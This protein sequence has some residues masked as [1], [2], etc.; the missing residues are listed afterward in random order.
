MKAFTLIALF[1]TAALGTFAQAPTIN[2]FPVN[3]TSSPGFSGATGSTMTI[4]GTN[5]TGATAVTFGG[6]PASSFTVVSPTQIT[7]VVA[8]GSKGGVT[9]TTPQGTATSA[10]TFTYL[11]LSRIVTSFGGYWSSTTA[12]NNATQ[13]DSSHNLLGFTYNGS[14]YSTGAS[15]STLT[16]RGISFTPGNYRAFPVSGIAGTYSS[17]AVYLAIANKVDGNPTLGNLAGVS[18]ATIRSVLIDGVRGLDLGTGVTNLPTTAIMT[19]NLSSISIPTIADAEPDIL[20]TQIAD[21]SVGNDRFEFVDAAG[22]TVG[23][24]LTQDMTALPTFGVYR[25]DLFGFTPGT[26]YNVANPT[27]VNA[28]NGTKGIRIVGLKLSDFG[29]T[30]ANASSVKAM[31]ITPSGNSDYAFIAY[32]ARIITSAPNIS[33]NDGTTISSVCNNGNAVLSVIGTASGGGA[34]TY[35]WERSTNG[36]TIWSA[37]SN[38]GNFSGAT[39]NSL[40]VANP[41]SNDKYR[42]TVSE[43]GGT[44]NTSADF[45][46]T[47]SPTT[48]GGT[49]AGSTS[50]CTGTNSTTFTLSGHT[51]SV[52]RWESSTNGFS[53]ITT[54]AN[55]TASLTVT[56]VSATTQYR[57]VVQSGACSIANSTVASVTYNASVGGSVA[58]SAP[59]VCTGTNSTT[60]TLSGHTGNI[61]RWESST[62]NFSSINTIANTT[63]TLT[64]T[65]LTAT[66]QYRAII[67]NASCASANSSAATVTVNPTTVGG[68]IAGSA[69]VCTGSNSTTL[70]LSSNTGTIVKWQSST[71]NFS[72]VITDVANTTTTLTASNLTATT[73]YRA[74]VQ[75]GICASVNSSTATVTV[76]P[77]S[78]GGTVAGSASVCTGSNS[79][80]LTLSSNTGTIVKWQSSTDNFSSVITDI[81]NTT[82][83]LT[84]SNLTA[85]TQYR[86]VVQSG[87]CASANS[88][89]ATVTVSPATVG[90]TITGS[91]S[92]CTGSNSA[93]L[94]LSGSTGTIVKWQSSTDNFSSVITDIANTTATLT[95]T[96]LNATTQYRAVV[97][98]GVCASANSSTA[99]V[100]VSPATVGGTI[101]GSAAVCTGSNFTTLTLSVNTGS[102]VKW[103]SSTDNF[104]SVITDIANTT[105]TLIASNLNA[106]TKYRAVVQSGVCASANSSIATITVSPAS[107]GGTIAGSA[108]VCTG[109]NSTTL[110]LSGSTGTIVKWQSSTD[111]FSSLITD[112]ANTTNTLTATNLT[113]TTRYRAVLQSG[114]C[115]SAISS[116]ATIT[117]NAVGQWIGG[118]NGDWNLPSNWCGGVPSTPSH[119]SIPSGSIVTITSG[120]ALA[121]TVN[122]AAGGNLVMNGSGNL[123]ISAGGTFINNGTF[124]A[125]ASTTGKVSFAGN[126]T[127]SG[128]TTF[129]NIDTYG[130]LD[131]GTASTVS[132]EF[133]LQTGASVTGHSPTYLCPTS[134]LVYNIGGT[135]PRSLEWPS[136]SS[137]Q[138]LPSNVIVKNNT[139][140]NFPVEGAGYVCN[141]LTV[142]PGSAL[143]QNFSGS[144][145]PLT[146]GRH[147]TIDGLLTLGDDQGDD[148][149]LGG[150]WTRNQGVFNAN[151]RTVTFTSAANSVITGPASAT[152]DGNG[153][154][155]GETFYNINLNK[156]A[157]SNTVELG[158]NITVVNEL[159]VSKGTFDLVNN[160]VTIVSNA[161]TT[162]H[163]APVSA[164]GATVNY[165]GTGRFIIQRHLS[166]GSGSTSRR[167]RMLTAPVQAAGAPTISQAWQEGVS[168]A[169]RNAPVDPWPGFG[170]TI[171]KSTT[172]N[173]ADGYDQGSTNN[174]SIYG[175][176][177]TNGIMQW[178]TLPSTKVAVT[179]HEGYMLFA[180]GNRS[181]IVSTPNINANTT[182]LEPRGK[183]N[184]GNIQKSVVAGFQIIGNPYASAID[185]NKLTFSNYKVGSTTYNGSAGTI[186]GIGLT[187][188]MW[189]PK[190][191][192]SSS[193]GKWITCSSNGDGTYTITPSTS[194]LPTDGV[195]Q[196]GVA[197]MIKSDDA[198]GSLFFHETDKVSTSS[199][200][201]IASRGTGSNQ[202]ISSLTSTLMVGTGASA[203]I[204][205]GVVNSY[206]P[207]YHDEVDNQDAPGISTFNSNDA[208]RIKSE[209]QYLAIERR[210]EVADNDTI[211][212][213]LQNV[214]K[215]AYTLQFKPANMSSLLTAVLEDNFTGAATPLNMN[216]TNSIAFSVT[217]DVKSGAEDRFR[218]VFKQV[219]VLPIKFSSLKAYQQNDNIAVQWTVENEQNMVKYEVEKSANG[220]DF[221][222]VN[223]TKATG[224]DH[225]TTTYNW[226]DLNS[227]KGDNFYR[228]KSVSLNGSIE[229]SKIVKVSLG[230][231]KTG[232]SVYPNPVK[233]G[234]IGLQLSNAPA[235]TYTI[236]LLNNAGQV[237]EKSTLK[238]AGGNA[239]ETIKPNNYLSAGNYNLE[240]SG[241][242]NY[243]QVI[244]VLVEAVK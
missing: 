13:P 20:I 66:T 142:E 17:G 59:A 231:N 97:Q 84:S 115:T 168:N 41:V 55:T 186:Q 74:V 32:N 203:A 99:T 189:D 148:I 71:D 149:T 176:M 73:Q 180:R 239:S 50:F 63:N 197:F 47:N 60:M 124:D 175:P 212:L 18:S 188:Y 136:V 34:L 112:I 81:A 111:N 178:Y 75:S 24:F 90:G 146:V 182:I 61:L 43:S 187:Y 106:T 36:G 107:V 65:N 230:K 80:T 147:V 223:T 172:Y 158:S 15:D 14:F 166:I 110:T 70:T 119:V 242:G 190:T 130:A 116:S 143:L 109:S 8:G 169:N 227:I 57:A 46:L 103:Q 154:F 69:S 68:T 58:G 102:I 101:A 237:V 221:T 85:T 6:T 206:H 37:V 235:G 236:I 205:E 122:I 139:T 64:A 44:T 209:G 194:E 140:I 144:S 224:N 225:S 128:T 62:N 21:P 12:V 129:K 162:A 156:A 1:I 82:T 195:I 9:V 92:V 105:N 7:A 22:V 91:A 3:S 67:Q 29:I 222:Q 121:S 199:P 198:N 33:Q 131:F 76:S 204:S 89:T 123:V 98:N 216:D 244:K 83:T 161:I 159:K 88:S 86:A 16:A 53:V 232:V 193:V 5:F 11:P 100:T 200:E 234:V 78:I 157:A 213:S 127:I 137:G 10:G 220:R 191:S 117:V 96:N 229:Y 134:S 108:S 215:K 39:T 167:W 26:S 118:A 48:V 219:G 201:G 56:N 170:T 165:S 181:I 125:S 174:P 79:T 51:G 185:F 217:A 208:L 2:A 155:G 30:A 4:N 150:N 94:T 138:G 19:F 152:R 95:A 141:D 25:Q 210:S 164:T 184:V 72:S 218:I 93:T 23:T 163:V 183:I 27:S 35:T 54:I 52:I 40:T 243:R 151:G 145:A 173:A 202:T 238:H 160:D 113:A 214:S 177:T 207:G 179:S 241:P 135:Y 132:G 42:A 192:G 87:V 49:V 45:T 240:V 233:D 38:G 28:S 196:S 211:F 228:I 120:N 171:T 31:K 153:A 114:T 126:G 104:G 226:L 77:I 133:T